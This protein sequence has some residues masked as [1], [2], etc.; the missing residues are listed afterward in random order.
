MTRPTDACW[1]DGGEPDRDGR[2][3]LGVV[4]VPM[5]EAY[6]PVYARAIVIATK[7]GVFEALR[8]VVGR[9]QQIAEACATD[10]RATAKLMNLLSRCAISVT[11]TVLHARSPCEAMAPGRFPRLGARRDPDE[12]AGVE[13]DRPA[14]DLRPRRP[15]A[16]RP[17][18]DVDRRLERVSARNACAGQSPGVVARATGPCAGG[19]Q[20]HARHRRI[21][22]LFLGG[23]L[24]ATSAAARDRSRPPGRR[25]ARRAAAGA[26][27]DGGPSRPA[28]RGRADRR[29]R[30]GAPTTSSWSSA[31]SITSTMRRTG[32]S[33]PV[34]RVPC[35]LVD[36]SSSATPC[37]RRLR[38]R[39]ANRGP[40]STCTSL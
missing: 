17:R 3:R 36:T 12:G 29:P 5:L 11:A 7:L 23:A 31:S 4:P 19:G 20:G 2:P 18:D 16:R 37:A 32:C 28:R 40:S 13:L 24:P 14:R 30:R 10:L 33:S 6:A 8:E 15:A 39:E 27:G 1:I 34:R 9:L 25:G 21:P 22:R 26:R 38:A 35:D